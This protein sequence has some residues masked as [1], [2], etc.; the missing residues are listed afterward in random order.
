MAARTRKLRCA[1]C[2]EP[3]DPDRRLDAEYCD[4]SCRGRAS[5]LSKSVEQGRSRPGSAQKRSRAAQTRRSTRP[6]DL[7]ISYRKAVDVVAGELTEPH[8]PLTE[9]NE[10]YE[11]RGLHARVRAAEILS[12]LLTDRQRAAL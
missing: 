5:E 12:P 3:L 6:P 1:Y 8:N 9:S 7:R 2:R 11:R 4:S 10:A